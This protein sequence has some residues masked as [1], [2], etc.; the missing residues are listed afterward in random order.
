MVDET[1]EK[2]NLD[3]NQKHIIPIRR[4]TT[5]TYLPLAPWVLLN[6]KKVTQDCNLTINSRFYIYYFGFLN[7]LNN[8]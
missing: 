2:D 8:F 1:H 7:A 3:E 6:L 4:D 5:W